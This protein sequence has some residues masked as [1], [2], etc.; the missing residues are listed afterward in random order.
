M[1]PS[2]PAS[3]DV[4]PMH[5]DPEFVVVAL[6]TLALFALPVDWWEHV[7]ARYEDAPWLFGALLL[8]LAGRLGIR[9]AGVMATGRERA[10]AQAAPPSPP[11]PPP[12]EEGGDAPGVDADWR[13]LPSGDDLEIG[14]ADF[15]EAQAFH[16]VSER[17]SAGPPGPPP[18][19][20]EV[21]GDGGGH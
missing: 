10:A 17:P 7:R 18:A 9:I 6:L 4:K 2:T 14:A 3:Y 21:A 15:E 8:P 19:E 20:S 1:N 11:V 16:E 5:R 13:I 12:A